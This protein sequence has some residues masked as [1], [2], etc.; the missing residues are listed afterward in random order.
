MPEPQLRRRP[1]GSG[2]RGPAPPRP[3]AANQ[4]QAVALAVLSELGAM[5]EL[6][7]KGLRL[8]E[9]KGWGEFFARFKAPRA[10]NTKVLDERLTTNFLH[11]RGNYSVVAA[12]LLV[13][14]I[15][16]NPYVLLA[17]LCCALLLTFL[18]PTG[19]PRRAVRVG[20]RTL[21]RQERLAAAV[22]GASCIL[23]LTGAWYIL[24]FYGGAGVLLCL[25]HG[26]FRP[27]SIGS[28]TSRAAAEAQAGFTI[29]NAQNFVENVFGITGSRSQ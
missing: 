17:L 22:I 21:E 29:E 15:I 16:S 27:R 1:V 20:D 5:M 14:G 6:F 4:N 13:V 25:L 12:G 3:N 26:V 23:G 19:E 8:K 2:S 7:F 10:W 28:K 24:L 11:Y 9:M 18:F